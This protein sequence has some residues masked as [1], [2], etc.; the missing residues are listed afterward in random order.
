MPSPAARRPVVAEASAGGLILDDVDHPAYAALIRRVDRNGNDE[1]VIPKGHVEPGESLPQ[2]AVRE[3]REETGLTGEVVAPLGVLDY[4]FVAEE[5]RVHKTVHHYVL[6]YLQGC[7]GSQDPEVD[8]VAW[9][10]ID[11]LDRRLRYPSEQDLASRL[12]DALRGI[13]LDMAGS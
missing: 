4:W 1:W 2:T 9:L 11:E 13:R 3:V 8:G 7:P 12:R 5:N 10:S 6:R